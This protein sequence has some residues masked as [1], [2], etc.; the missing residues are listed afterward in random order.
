MIY[1]RFFVEVVW[2]TLGTI[3][4]CG[5][6]ISFCR[7]LF[8]CMLGTPGRG[9]VLV[10]SII[11]TPIHELGHA[12]MCLLFGHRITRMRLWS[13]GAKDGTL[14]S[15]SHRYNVRNPYQ[16]LGLLFI[17]VGP[18]LF[19]A[20]ILTLTLWLCFPAALSG[21]TEAAA[22][23]LDEGSGTG[24][25]LREGFL[26]IPAL[27]RELIAG[28]T[29]P[30][31]GRI[32]GLVVL[33]SVSLHMDLSPE[34]LRSALRALPLYGLIVLLLTVICGLIGAGAMGAVTGALAAVAAYMTAL[35]AVVF[36]AAGVQLAVALPIW[37]LRRLFR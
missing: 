19:G 17:G 29:V 12:L 5:L 3:V 30:L 27:V 9:I 22:A 32:V 6:G 37:A 1:V 13:P 11:G 21:Y 2:Y 28:E 33:L 14:G 24:A 31:W 26:L 25:L 7:W 20:G 8:L 15:V 36:A 10:T 4:L 18:I 23:L 34:D 35:F 16:V